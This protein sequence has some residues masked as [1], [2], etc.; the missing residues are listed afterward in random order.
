MLTIYFRPQ[1]NTIVVIIFI[2]SY[3]LSINNYTIHY[4]LIIL[5]LSG[6]ILKFLETHTLINILILLYQYP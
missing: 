3:N 2:I 1:F 4:L 6:G 5:L